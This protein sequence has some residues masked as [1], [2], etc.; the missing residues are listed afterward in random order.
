LSELEFALVTYSEAN[1]R[2]VQLRAQI[3]RLESLVAART[4]NGAA[5][6]GAAEQVSPQEA[7]FN[8]TLSEI[9][10]RL[11]TLRSEEIATRTELETLQEAISRSATNG[12][13]L[14][15]LERDYQNIQGRYNAAINN[16]N[17]ARMS[18]R[19]ET[20]AQGQ[21]I[22]VIEY[23]NAPRV[24]AGPNRPRIA[25]LG[26]GI[27]LMLAAGYFALLEVLNRTVRRPAELT[28][29]FNIIPLATIPYMES[30]RH[31]YARRAGMIAAMAVVVTGV[32][33][34]LWYIDTNY[35]PLEILVQRVLDRVSL[36]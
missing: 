9:Q 6:E 26:V 21:R 12:I 30:R 11:S 32:P 28:S 18:E 10:T 4:A 29:R 31:R 34:A 3:A 1:P 36:G 5:Q 2:V 20:T 19:I 22:S 13:A 17:Q 27:G 33:A 23:A 15:S 35:Q 8:A 25:I 14:A 7:L 24:A 16:L